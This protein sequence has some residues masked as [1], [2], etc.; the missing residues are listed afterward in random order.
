MSENKPAE[1]L[2]KHI[3]MGY[4]PGSPIRCQ[5]RKVIGGG[6]DDMLRRWEI[7]AEHQADMLRAAG[8]LA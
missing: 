7:L 8:L 3:G 5:C 2:R 6:P 1:I 4:G